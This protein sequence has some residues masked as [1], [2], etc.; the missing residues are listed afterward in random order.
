MCVA[1][2]TMCVALWIKTPVSLGATAPARYKSGSQGGAMRASNG[3]VVGSIGMFSFSLLLP[4]GAQA[5]NPQATA[6]EEI[7]VTAR[8]RAESVS[9]IP[10]SITAL[11]GDDVQQAGIERIDDIS[12]FVSNLN[13]STRADGNPNV[14]IRGMGSHGNTQG[15]GFYLDGVQIYT[16]ASARFGDIERLEVLKGP[17]GTLYGGSNIGGA[18]KLVTVR[19]DLTDALFEAVATF[20]D[21]STQD[22]SATINLP[23]GNGRAAL[24]LFGYYVADD[25]YLVSNNPIRLNGLSNA[26]IV[27]WPSVD[28]CGIPFD[29]GTEPQNSPCEELPNIA[30]RWRR[31]PNERE[32][33]GARLQFLVNLTD[34]VELVLSGR[35][36]DFDGGN[37]NW[38]VEDPDDLQYSRERELTFAGRR[39]HEV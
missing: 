14:T 31:H 2:W 38:R 11:S 27:F 13:L 6:L 29:F 25:G 24:R 26:D 30:E 34:D 28:V 21:E 33:Y 7:T 8:K 32:E 35:I 3:A 19:P 16:D 10:E 23:T 1:L 22:Y 18:V 17:Q 5:Q 20:G 12:G 37:N 39:R 4:A 36:Y 9:E 15:V